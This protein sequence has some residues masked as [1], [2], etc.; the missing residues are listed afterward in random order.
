VGVFLFFLKTQII[1]EASEGGI[2]EE[3]Q[4]GGVMDE[5]SG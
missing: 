1:E 5:A 2:R 4:G 3:A